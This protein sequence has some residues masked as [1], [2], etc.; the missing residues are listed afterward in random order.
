V[1]TTT[2]TGLLRIGVDLGGTKT[3]AV[4]VRLGGRDPEVLA[5]QRIPTARDLGYEHIVAQTR[6][7]VVD[8]AREPGIE[9]V[10]RNRVGIGVGM[11]GS[12]TTRGAEGRISEAPLVK[13]SNTTCLNG[14]PFRADLGAALGRTDV[15]FANDANCFALAE[16][17]W[18]AARG[19]RVAFGVILGTGVGGG[20]VIRDEATMLAP[21]GR[22]RAWD[23][24]Q[25]VAGEWGHVSLEPV[26]GPPC[27]CGRRGCLE[28]YL[29]GRAIER[30]YAARSG[31]TRR[32][33]E[34]AELSSEGD[35]VAVALLEERVEIFGRALSIV[36][37]VLDPDVIVLGGGVSNLALLYDEGVRAVGRW[38]FNDELRTR[39]VKNELGDSAGVLGAALLEPPDPCA[40]PA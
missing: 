34:I 2:N 39:I 13:N 3:E 30:D 16:A 9:D 32:L 38:V 10:T 5:R 25:G 22:A 24:A 12:V 17:V 26:T 8:V 7:L 36:I 14:R 20:V 33:P 21:S 18:G 4:A 6:A 37:D 29:S 23:G 35:K 11:P 27:Y 28:T 1:T 19:A 40:G 15:A 31:V